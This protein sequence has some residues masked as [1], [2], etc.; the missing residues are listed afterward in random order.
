MRSDADIM[1]RVQAG[2]RESFGLL[3]TRYA[4]RLLRVAQSKLGDAA[5]AEDVVQEAFLAA[6][7]ARQSYNPQFA[8]STWL[9]TILLNLCR[10]EWKRS[11]TRAI[12]VWEQ[13]DADRPDPTDERIPT[14][15]TALVAAESRQRLHNLL[16]ELPEPQADALRLRFFGE[17]PFDEIAT[18][19]E[20]S[21]SGAKRRVKTG[22]ERLSTLIRSLE[23][24]GATQSGRQ[25]EDQ[26]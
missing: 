21:L 20:C 19:M 18:T 23:T 16:E 17:L 2:D 4:P 11:Q 1:A 10:R 14:P 5:L 22:L 15:L 24:T 3:V 13:W 7:R 6:Y 25:T 26:T 8:L 9:W 12:S